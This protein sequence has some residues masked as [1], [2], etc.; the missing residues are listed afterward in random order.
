[1]SPGGAEIGGAYAGERLEA[2]RRLFLAYAAG[3]D[4]ELCFQG[5]ERELAELPGA[6]APPRGRLLLATIGGEPAGCA[7]LRPLDAETCEMKRL[8]VAPA[9]TGRGLGRR[10]AEA[11]IAEA[12]A[13]G[14]DRMRLDTVPATMPAATAL[15]AR[16]GFR[17]IPAYYANPLPGAAYFELALGRTRSRG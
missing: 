1:M 6:Y 16:L 15:Y 10:L 7:G 9:F 17:P 11:A 4:F 3:L 2:V 14:Y 8:Y 13:I 12:E 5:F